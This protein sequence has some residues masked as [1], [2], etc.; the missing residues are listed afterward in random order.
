MNYYQI[1]TF[2]NIVCMTYFEEVI[3]IFNI[4]EKKLRK[5]LHTNY[6]FG[7]NRVCC[8][9]SGTK[10][11]TSNFDNSIEGYD[12]ET[13]NLIYENTTFEQI[14]KIKVDFSNI[15]ILTDDQQYYRVNINSNHIIDE[16]ENIIDFELYEEDVF[17]LKRTNILGRDLHLDIQEG[18]FTFFVESD[19]IFLSYRYNPLIKIDKKTQQFIWTASMDDGYTVQKLKV[20]DNVV[21]TVCSFLTP[22]TTEYYLALFDINDGTR[23]K[24][25]KLDN[26]YHSFD[27]SN[28]GSI[29]ICSNGDILDTLT[30]LKVGELS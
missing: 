13:G 18:L 28:D 22:S 26:K 10:I 9:P 8:H 29:L 11:F 2:K 24:K 20:F 4:K 23:L 25:T 27:I 6:L 16:R 14:Q 21:V 19:F 30:H 15:H 1:E 17:F 3:H 12:I 7:G 5:E